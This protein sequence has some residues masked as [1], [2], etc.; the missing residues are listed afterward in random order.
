M[1][2]D[3]SSSPMIPPRHPDHLEGLPFGLEQPSDLFASFQSLF[4]TSRCLH[5]TQKSIQCVQF[6]GLLGLLAEAT[7][8]STNIHAS[9][10]QCVAVQSHQRHFGV[11]SL[12]V[13]S[14]VHIA[15][16]FCMS[17]QNDFAWQAARVNSGLSQAPEMQHEIL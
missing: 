10:F 14:C 12:G 8:A 5:W 6:I 7:P 17:D 1:S 4:L 15:L 3:P 11:R 13:F 2:V 9:S 16:G